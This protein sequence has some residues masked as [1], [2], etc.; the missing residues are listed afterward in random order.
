MR[1]VIQ[2]PYFPPIA[3]KRGRVYCTPDARNGIRVRDLHTPDLNHP[4]G[5]NTRWGQIPTPSL[6]R[7]NYPQLHQPATMLER[8]EFP[9]SNRTLSASSLKDRLSKLS[10]TPLRPVAALQARVECVHS[11]LSL[12]VP[13][14][15]RAKSVFSPMPPALSQR[16]FLGSA[17]SRPS[18][19]HYGPT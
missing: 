6:V 1:D 13:V 7:I 15:L 11:V 4:P 19:S 17:D 3:R 10:V 8:S 12:W 18:R 2:T 5:D 9:R 14:L 16:A